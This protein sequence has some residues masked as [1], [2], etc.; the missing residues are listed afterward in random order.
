MGC[1]ERVVHINVAKLGKRFG[2]YR[3]VRFFLRLKTK[4]LEKSDVLRE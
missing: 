2:E 1:T 4:V 3:I